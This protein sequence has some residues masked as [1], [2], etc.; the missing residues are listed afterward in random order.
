MTFFPLL[1]QPWVY[2]FSPTGIKNFIRNRNRGAERLQEAHK[3]SKNR[4]KKHVFFSLGLIH[5]WGPVR[6]QLQSER[7]NIYITDEFSQIYSV[8]GGFQC[9]MLFLPNISNF[10]I[11]TTRK[12]STLF[13]TAAF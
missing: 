13:F 1:F 7:T 4:R 5:D 12:R 2:V 3:S 6:S 9:K 10:F 8:G 11:F